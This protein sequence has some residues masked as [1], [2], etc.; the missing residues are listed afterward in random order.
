MNENDKNRL[1]HVLDSAR[2]TQEFLK[3][4]SFDDLQSN[5]MLAN[6]IVRSLEVV[7][8]AAS[9]ISDECR[10]THGSIPW[11]N[12][13]AMRNRLVHAYFDINYEV[14]WNTVTE[15]IPPLI[16]EIQELLKQINKE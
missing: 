14:I 9:Q 5:R 2:E 7:G 15:D 12:I 8:E 13:I 4:K 6:A 10:K 16:H 1:F 11:R 3:E